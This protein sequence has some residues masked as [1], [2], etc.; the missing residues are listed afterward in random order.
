M[1]KNFKRHEELHQFN[2]IEEAKEYSDFK[3]DYLRKNG[4]DFGILLYKRIDE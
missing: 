1:E 4:Y 3:A 2:T